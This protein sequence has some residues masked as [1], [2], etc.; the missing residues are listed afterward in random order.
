LIEENPQLINSIEIIDK[1]AALLEEA[2]LVS[3]EMWLRSH[4]RWKLSG[5]I[6]K[7]EGT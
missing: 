3:S 6:P 1:Y 2:I 5:G 7:H 4:K